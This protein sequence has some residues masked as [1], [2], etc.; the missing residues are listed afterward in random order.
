M[1]H[2]SVV[3]IE[4]CESNEHCS[5]TVYHQELDAI[6]TKNDDGYIVLNPEVV[7]S[8]K[9]TVEAEEE[10]PVEESEEE[11]E[12]EESEEETPKKPTAKELMEQEKAK[13]REELRQ[14]RESEKTAMKSFNKDTSV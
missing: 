4:D 3:V 1:H 9:K 13:K 11:S 10:Q 6:L 7:E 5:L 2:G 8:I 12:E 14:Q